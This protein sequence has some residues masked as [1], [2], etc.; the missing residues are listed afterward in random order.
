MRSRCVLSASMCVVRPTPSVPATT[1]SQPVRSSSDTPGT[2]CPY[3][4]NRAIRPPCPQLRQ[5]RTDAL[6]QL[7]LLDLDRFGRVHHGEVELLHDALV[8]AE[9][10]ALEEPVGLLHVVMEPEV[11][12]GLVAFELGPAR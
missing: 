2:P 5:Q 3:H 8:L 4:S 10:P 12:A 9:D 1:I 7:A 6:T 11:H